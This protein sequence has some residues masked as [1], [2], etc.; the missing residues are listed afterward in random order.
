MSP[1][2]TNILAVIFDFDDTLIGDS[3]TKLLSQYGIDTDKFWGKEVW[4]LVEDGYDPTLAWLGLFLDK[5]GQRKPLGRL[6]NGTLTEFGAHLDTGFAPGIPSLFTDLQRLV[7][8]HQDISIEFYIVSGGLETVI[9][10][11]KIMKYVEEVYGCLLGENLRTGVV[12]KIRRCVTFT[13][14]TRYLFEINKGLRL[15]DTWSDPYRVNAAVPEHERRIPFRNM[16]YVGDG[17][18]DIPCFSL[19]KNMGGTAFGVFDPSNEASAKRAFE[20]LLQ[21]GRVVSSHR[22]EYRKTDDLGMFLRTAVLQ[23]CSRISLERQQP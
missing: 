3:T 11:S 9:R 1:S 17:L 10:G 19:V 20:H 6:T 22:A 5:V 4:Q 18:T 16:I 7:R 15:S 2:P 21:T 8:Q 13:E 23:Q 12:S 14:K